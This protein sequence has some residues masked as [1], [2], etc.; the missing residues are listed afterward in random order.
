MFVFDLAGIL[1]TR[2]VS[3]EE[4]S[5]KPSHLKLGLVLCDL[6]SDH[7]QSQ[8]FCLDDDLKERMSLDYIS[9]TLAVLLFLIAKQLLYLQ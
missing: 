2:R 9:F 5:H 4:P 3:A 7:L 1:K 6:S 8:P